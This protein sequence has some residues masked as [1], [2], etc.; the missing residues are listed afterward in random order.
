[1]PLSFGGKGE[2]PKE[3]LSARKL[4]QRVAG[5]LKLALKVLT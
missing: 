3:L 5:E 4:G 1:M 2:M